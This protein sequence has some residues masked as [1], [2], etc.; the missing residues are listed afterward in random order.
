MPDV[1]FHQ[2]GAAGDKGGCQLLPASGDLGL[3][4]GPAYALGKHELALVV[5]YIMVV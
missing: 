4:T 2:R 3:E 1:L 5:F